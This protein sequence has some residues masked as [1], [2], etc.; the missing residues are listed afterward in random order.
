[1]NEKNVEKKLH[2]FF[3]SF[4]RKPYEIGEQQVKLK[5]K[6]KKFVALTYCVYIAHQKVEGAK[7]F[8]MHYH[9]CLTDLCKY[10]FF[11]LPHVVC[12]VCTIYMA[13]WHDT[14][15]SNHGRSDRVHSKCKIIYG[16]NKNGLPRGI[17]MAF[18]NNVS[19]CDLNYIYYTSF[20]YLHPQ[21]V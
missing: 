10:Y 11:S 9:H 8:R 21:M 14:L 5:I 18:E 13:W 19:R 2:T 16:I 4:V 7:I 1:M 12:S 3:F 6:K 17:Q 15:N 20:H